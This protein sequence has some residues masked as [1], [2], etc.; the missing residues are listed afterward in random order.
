MKK[1]NTMPRH[2]LN[3]IIA[4]YIALFDKKHGTETMQIDDDLYQAADVYL[5][6]FD[7][8]YILENDLPF[9]FVVAWFD[10]FVKS[11]VHIKAYHRVRLRCN[12]MEIKHMDAVSRVVI[13]V[14]N[15]IS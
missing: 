4:E 12:N 2:T 1:Y 6:F 10:E 7:M 5:S 9:S 13:G 8:V 11:R 15:D 3:N 14:I